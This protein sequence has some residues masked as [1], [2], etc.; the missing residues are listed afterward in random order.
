MH[1]KTTNRLL[2]GIRF[3]IDR[4]GIV[5]RTATRVFVR[6]MT[7]TGGTGHR[8][9]RAKGATGMRD[10]NKRYEDSQHDAGEGE[11]V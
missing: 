5:V 8:F 7:A 10:G 4:R 6:E 1:A 11:H 2:R 3:A 9:V